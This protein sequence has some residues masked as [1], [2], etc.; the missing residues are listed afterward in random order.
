M[1]FA[2]PFS[3]IFERPFG[4][5]P[6]S[7]AVSWWLSG[8]IDAANCIAAYAA[9]GAA[10]YAASKV[11]LTGD[12]TYN[13]TPIF[14]DPTF[15][16]V[17]GWKFSTQPLD[18]HILPGTGM[19]WI[20]RYAMGGT[21][22]QYSLLGHYLAA[23][24]RVEINPLSATAGY[25]CNAGN[26]AAG[27]SMTPGVLCVAGTTGYNNGV[28]AATGLTAWGDPGTKTVLIGARR[29]EDINGVDNYCA[30]YVLAV[31]VYNAVLDV[32]QVGELTT[33]MAAL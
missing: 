3:R 12:T 9:K 28:S 27:A 5:V 24:R 30:G 29:R 7:A 22:N 4:G 1:T 33:A 13:L 31:A 15:N 19:T 11:N 17:T 8:G 23:N 18:T 21:G 2:S 26:S 6:S 25:Y 20:V 10:D 14:T 16:T 32:T